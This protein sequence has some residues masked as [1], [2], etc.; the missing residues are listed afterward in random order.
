MATNTGLGEQ[1]KSLLFA[2]F[3]YRHLFGT[4]LVQKHSS[5]VLKQM[6]ADGETYA[7]ETLQDVDSVSVSGIGCQT[8]N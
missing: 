3:E 2:E 6:A 7:V 1:F 4:A 5:L 8:K